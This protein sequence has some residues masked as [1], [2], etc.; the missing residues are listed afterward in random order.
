M[1]LE[2][3]NAKSTDK[4]LIEMSHRELIYEDD[5]VTN[6]NQSAFH[7][8]KKNENRNYTKNIGSK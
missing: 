1:K 4:L 6:S 2:L 3:W 5:V 7:N 8:T